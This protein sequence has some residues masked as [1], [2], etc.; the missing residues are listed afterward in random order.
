MCFTKGTSGI[1]VERLVSLRSFIV[2]VLD[3]TAWR[4]GEKFAP[5]VYSSL[6]IYKDFGRIKEPQKSNFSSI[7]AH[8]SPADCK[9]CFISVNAAQLKTCC[10]T[11]HLWTI[12]PAFSLLL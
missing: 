12:P 4:T 7:T 5:C 3:V 1:Q 9:V 2:N 6:K 11:Q 10:R 8:S